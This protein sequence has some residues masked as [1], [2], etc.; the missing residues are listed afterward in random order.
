MCSRWKERNAKTIE[1]ENVK[2]K[3]HTIARNMLSHGI[4]NFV[5]AS[6]SGLGK[7][8]GNRKKLTGR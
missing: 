4:G 2:K 1:I 8:G 6:G 5:W 3:I 7:I